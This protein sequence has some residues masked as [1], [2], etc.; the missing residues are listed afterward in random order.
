MHIPAIFRMGL[1]LADFFD[2]GT[3]AILI[4]IVALMIPIVSILVRHQ[5]RMAEII[6]TAKPQLATDRAEIEALRR[7]IQELKQLVHQQAI[8]MDT[9]V[10][11][12]SKLAASSQ[13]TIA[14]RLTSG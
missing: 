5:Q 10:E 8:S 14:D 7:E 6:H 1:P 13:E 12:Q 9:F 4:P 3:L 11:R 2:P